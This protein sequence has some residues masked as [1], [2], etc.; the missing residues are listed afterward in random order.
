VLLEWRRLTPYNQPGDGVFASPQ[1]QGKQLF[2][3]ERLRRNLQVV[4]KRLGIKKRVGWRAFRHTLSTM[5]RAYGEDIATQAELLRNSQKVALEHYTQAIPES[6]RAAQ[7][8]VLT[9]IFG[10]PRVSGR[11]ATAFNR[12][13]QRDKVIW[14]QV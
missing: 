10:K 13:S 1:M 8:R 14:E 7:N 2:W 3:P 4:A 5:L 6:K 12:Q 11:P 9:Q